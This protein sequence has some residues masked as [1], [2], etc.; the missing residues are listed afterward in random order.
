MIDGESG[1]VKLCGW[2]VC[3]EIGRIYLCGDYGLRMSNLRC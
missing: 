1:S 2:I 3:K